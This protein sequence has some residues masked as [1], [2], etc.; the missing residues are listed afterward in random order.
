MN[1]QSKISGGKVKK[2]LLGHTKLLYFFFDASSCETP[3]SASS[4]PSRLTTKAGSDKA[5]SMVA[6]CTGKQKNSLILG[7]KPS[8]LLD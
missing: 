3:P 2:K 4:A 5:D 7:L 1:E 6:F 8:R